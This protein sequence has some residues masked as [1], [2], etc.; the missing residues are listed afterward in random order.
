[1]I[2]RPRL[3]TLR[4]R[5]VQLPVRELGDG[6]TLVRRSRDH[7]VELGPPAGAEALEPPGSQR[8]DQRLV[9]GTPSQSQVPAECA[10]LLGP[11]S[12]DAIDSMPSR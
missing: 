12:E 11:V 10:E 2:A 8:P 9:F 7:L 1:M 5:E 6:P 3:A 4:I